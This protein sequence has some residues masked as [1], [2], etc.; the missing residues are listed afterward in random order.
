MAKALGSQ[1]R[2]SFGKLHHW[3]VG[4]SGQHYMFQLFQLQGYGT[5]NVWIAV[6][7]QIHPP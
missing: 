5:V 7:K 1:L 2:Q 4:K 3:F 6:S